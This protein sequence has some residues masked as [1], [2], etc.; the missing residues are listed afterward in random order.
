MDAHGDTEM[1][2][3]KLT[4]MDKRQ[5]GLKRGGY[6]LIEWEFQG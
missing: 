1:V 2:R 4:L 5:R 3:D 6:Q